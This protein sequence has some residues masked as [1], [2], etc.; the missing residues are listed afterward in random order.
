MLLLRRK[1]SLPPTQALVHAPRSS[2][3]ETVGGIAAV[4]GGIV[5]LGSRLLLWGTV[6]VI[7]LRVAR[8]GIQLL[9]GGSSGPA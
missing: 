6:L 3:L 8:G 2:S 9:V 1:K 7:V 5:V 4:G